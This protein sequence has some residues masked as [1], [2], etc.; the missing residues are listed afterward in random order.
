MSGD[1]G[2]LVRD[3]SGDWRAGDPQASSAGAGRSQPTFL[4]RLRKVLA[5]VRGS[6]GRKTEGRQA[7]RAPANEHTQQTEEEVQTG[8]LDAAD[9][10]VYQHALSQLH[11]SQPLAQRLSVLEELCELCRVYNFE[12]LPA[13][14]AM[15]R[16]LLA[17]GQSPC[18][19]AV[20]CPILTA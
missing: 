12:D 16:D 18:V 5:G 6:G 1:G 15:C 3:G 19:F 20:Q 9:R 4:S 17:P 10:R 13:I 14:W 2:R 8:L 7:S 11:S